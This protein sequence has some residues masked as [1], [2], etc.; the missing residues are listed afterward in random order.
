MFEKYKK[1]KY[2][3]FQAMTVR[4]SSSGRTAPIIAVCIY[5][6]VMISIKWSETAQKNALVSADVIVT[7]LLRYHM[8]LLYF[9]CNHL[10]FIVTDNQFQHDKT[11][12][13]V[14]YAYNAST[15]F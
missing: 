3:D 14:N 11:F 2:P 5:R 13:S 7:Q 4:L 12:I 9:V 1:I 15:H 6:L 8:P 10:I